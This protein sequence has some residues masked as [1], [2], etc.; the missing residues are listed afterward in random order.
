MLVELWWSLTPHSAS[1]STHSCVVTTH[2]R[3]SVH[4]TVHS[5][6]RKPV[7]QPPQSNFSWDVCVCAAQ[8]H[9]GS[10]C[11][12]THTRRHDTA[13]RCA[14]RTVP[15]RSIHKE[16]GKQDVRSREDS[17]SGMKRRKVATNREKLQLVKK[18]PVCD[19]EGPPD[20]FL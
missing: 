12:C 13:A 5:Q 14:A 9:R 17:G 20:F 15:N 16:V 8:Q 18:P 19:S 3:L 7:K 2:R 4:L 1:V 10:T 11:V 6:E